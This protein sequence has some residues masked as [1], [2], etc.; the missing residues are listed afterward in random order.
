M[1]LIDITVKYFSILEPYYFGKK[2]PTEGRLSGVQIGESFNVF[3]KLLQ[4]HGLENVTFVGPDSMH[5]S[6]DDQ[7]ILE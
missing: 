6:Q 2:F 5:V 4:Q 3:Y 7:L 1:W